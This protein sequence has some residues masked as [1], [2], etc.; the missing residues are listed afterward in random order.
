MKTCAKGHTYQGDENYRAR[1]GKCPVC[2]R[3]IQARY[4]SSEKGR[5][6]HDTYNHGG[7]GGDRY[8]RYKQSPK[9]WQQALVDRRAKALGR[10]AIRV[11]N[12]EAEDPDG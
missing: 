4:D 5:A 8:A 7:K 11:N 2:F 6:R 1:Q 12:R 3:E 9:G 10:R